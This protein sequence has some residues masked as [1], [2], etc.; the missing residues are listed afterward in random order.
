MHTYG[1]MKEEEKIYG[2][3]FV[4]DKFIDISRDMNH[5]TWILMTNFF[6][7]RVLESMSHI[8]NKITLYLYDKINCFEMDTYGCV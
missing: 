5:F 4:V 3:L 2:V 8:L 6:S 1:C 7:K